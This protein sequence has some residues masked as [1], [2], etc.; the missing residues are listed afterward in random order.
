MVNKNMQRSLGRIDQLKFTLIQNDCEI[1][2]F[3]E[4]IELNVDSILNEMQH[5]PFEE[6]LS[7]YTQR[8]EEIE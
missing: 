3:K 2:K 7:T 4:D 6:I 5:A 1:I 8:I